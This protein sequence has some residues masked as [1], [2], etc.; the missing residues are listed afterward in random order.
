[1]IESS[2]SIRRMR[3]HGT[4]EASP[5]PVRI[6]FRMQSVLFEKALEINPQNAHAWHNK[7]VA[8]SR[9]GWDTE[10]R[11]AFSCAGWIALHGGSK[12]AIFSDNYYLMQPS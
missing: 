8:L 2:K 11:F 6:C 10:A 12:K 5:R 7:G 3:K 1:M 4:I 9:L